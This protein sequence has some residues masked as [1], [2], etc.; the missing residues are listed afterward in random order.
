VE[1]T[2]SSREPIRLLA[3]SLSGYLCGTHSGLLA[4]R[5]GDRLAL[6]DLARTHQEL[7]APGGGTATALGSAPWRPAEEARGLADALR[8]NLAHSG[9]VDLVLFGSQARGETTGF[10]DVDAILVIDDAAAADAAALRALRPHVL[11]AQ[12]AVIAYQPMQHHGFEVVTPKLLRRANHAVRMPAVALSEAR[13]LE[14]SAVEAVFAG[15]DAEEARA[16]LGEMVR[17]TAA[18][19]AWPPHAWHLHRLVSMFELL[20]A[21]YLQARGSPVPK[22]RSFAEAR[23]DFDERWWPYDVLKQ[24]RDRWPRRSV[25]TLRAGAAA[26]RNPWVA[27][28]AWRRAVPAK[29]DTVGAM[30]SMEC[31]GALHALGREMCERAC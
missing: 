23:S 11:A 31:L 8:S 21:L 1:S 30:L 3:R 6:R 24:V 26:L 5:R 13:S 10:S 15:D 12:R 19:S 2:V 14:G 20:P 25:R 16:A 4:S 17:T 22:W 27:A 9:V 7:S 28:A 18:F 29:A